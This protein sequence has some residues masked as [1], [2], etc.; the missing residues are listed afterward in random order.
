M[1]QFFSIVLVTN[2]AIFFD[3][4]FSPIQTQHYECDFHVPL[5]LWTVNFFF[6][7]AVALARGLSRHKYRV[8]ALD[9]INRYGS[10]KEHRRY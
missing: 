1:V 10:W 9:M 6:F 2:Q 8:A 3:I 5:C 4:P 7:L